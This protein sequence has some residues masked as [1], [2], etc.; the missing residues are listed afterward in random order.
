MTSDKGSK[1]GKLPE[2]LAAIERCGFATWGSSPLPPG[3]AERFDPSRIPV[4]GIRHVRQWGIQ[5][6][7]ER[8]LPGRERTSTADQ[9][10]WQVVL[11]A[12][13]GSSYEVNADLIVA[14]AEQA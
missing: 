2:K 8:A 14:A 6:D 13:D 9:E 11:I 4:G 10:L 12:K 7:D 5:V 3:L 1:T